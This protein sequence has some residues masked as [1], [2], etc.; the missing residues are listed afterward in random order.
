MV[1]TT[2]NIRKVFLAIAKALDFVGVDD[3][4]HAHRVAYIAYECAKRLGWSELEQER[5]FYA[6]LVHDCGVSSTQEHENLLQRMNPE[7]SSR[8]CELGFHALQ[9]TQL[10]SEFAN[11]VRYH[12]TPWSELAALPLNDEEKSVAAL[13]H[14]ADR[15]DFLRSQ[16]ADEQHAYL[17]IANKDSIQ[18]TILAKSGTGFE[19]NMAQAM[20]E[21]VMLDG[22]WYAME[23]DH[24]ESIAANFNLYQK[25]NNSLDLGQFEELALLLARIVDAKSPFTYQHG[26]KVAQLCRQLSL[27]IGFNEYQAEC[28]YIAGLLHD[29][30][31]LRTP[32]HILHSQNTLTQDERNQIKRHAVDTYITL[33]A[34]FPNSL[35]C[36]WAGNHHERLNGS[37]YPYHLKADEL[38]TGSRIVAIIDVFQALSQERPYKGRHSLE[39]VLS[40]MK[41]MIDKG[42]LDADLFEVIKNNSQAYY[43]IS[44]QS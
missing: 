38:D 42:E 25:F 41:P 31:K 32:D 17:L 35:I 43:Q 22:F 16:Y 13:I 33:E 26:E 36:Q 29:I 44:T 21:L 3:I 18:E 14:L 1:N 40:I 9:Q 28:L 20:A 6:G 19:A 15:V 30:G 24:I 5:V 23:Y 7:N 37:G 11:V 10:L 27:D 4:H 2:F 39:A 12:H 34:M 8:H